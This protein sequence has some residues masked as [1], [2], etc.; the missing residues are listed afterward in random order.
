MFAAET[1]HP[2]APR[3]HTALASVYINRG[4][5]PL[6]VEHLQRARQLYMGR[7]DAGTALH[8]L[9]AYCVFSERAPDEA[10]SW[11]ESLV[12]ITDDKYTVNSLGWL[13]NAVQ[14]HGCESLDVERVA[15]QLRA[16]L[17]DDGSENVWGL[18]WRLYFET[19]RLLALLGMPFK[20]V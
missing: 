8:R 7:R 3:V 4:D 14:A 11:L 5:M 6:V 13:V 18:E 17:L 1:A 15:T 16:L 19:A 20:R 9:A 10:Y 2:N 12:T